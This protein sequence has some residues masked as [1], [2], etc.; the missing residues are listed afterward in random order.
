MIITGYLCRIITIVWKA[1][2]AHFST[3][4]FNTSVEQRHMFSHQPQRSQLWERKNYTA[5]LV[6]G[7]RLGGICLQT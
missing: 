2:Y 4:Y 6:Q 3:V 1:A 5:S 7:D